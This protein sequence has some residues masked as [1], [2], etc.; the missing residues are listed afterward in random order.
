MLTFA[1]GPLVDPSFQPLIQK[2]EPVLLPVQ[3]FDPVP[4]PAAEQKQRICEGVQLELLLHHGGQTVDPFPQIRVPAGNIHPVGSGL[5]GA[6]NPPVYLTFTKEALPQS[7]LS[8]VLRQRR[9]SYSAVI[10]LQRQDSSPAHL[11]L[12]RLPS[13]CQEAVK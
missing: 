4:A 7:S 8:A 13:R 9:L 2:N 1:P 3:P 5:E 12:R 11:I 6:F 10:L